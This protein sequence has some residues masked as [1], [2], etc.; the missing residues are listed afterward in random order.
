V[1]AGL[2]EIASE[3]AEAPACLAVTWAS[4][5][6]GV[7]AAIVTGRPGCAPGRVNTAG[8]PAAANIRCRNRRLQFW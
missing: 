2:K 4:L 6:A 8:V 1:V 5:M 3:L 7:E